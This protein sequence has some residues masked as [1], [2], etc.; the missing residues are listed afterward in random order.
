MG[1]CAWGD[2]TIKCLQGLAWWC[3]DRS[4]RGKSLDVVT[5]Y[6]HD[7]QLDAIE[8]SEL[9]YEELKKESNLDKP[10][11]FK[12]E[13]WTEWEESVYNYFA[14]HRNSK[15]VPYSYVIRKMPNPT[16][17]F[18][19]EREYE[20]IYFARH[21]GTAF[22]RDSKHVL[23]IL[24][25]LTNGTSAE[26]WMKG[27]TCGRLAFLALQ[28][29]YDGKAEG[30]RRKAVVRADLEKIF[31]RNEA[32]FPFETF[33]TK[34]Q[35]IFNVLEKYGM[36]E[37]EQNKVNYLLDK[38][39]CPDKRFQN[40]V[41]IA[42]ANYSQT[43]IQAATYLQTQ[44]SRIFPQAQP[45]SGRYKKRG[46]A[47]LSKEQGGRGHWRGGGRGRGRGG[48]GRG[49]GRG[50]GG[51][52]AKMENG[53]DISDPCRW[54]EPDEPSA[55]TDKTC[56]EILNNPQRQAAIDKRKRKR[57]SSAV[58]ASQNDNDRARERSEL[59][60]A[61]MNA[62]GQRNTSAVCSRTPVNGSRATSAANRGP[63]SQVSTGQS[64][65]ASIITYD[66]LG[67]IVE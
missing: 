17:P 5:F 7:A 20:I 31:Y 54:Y 43:F 64:D 39:N 61:L 48:R 38:I 10:E 65:S 13:K 52:G 11:K 44:V 15:G 1:G 63:P 34:L 42:R 56:R 45:T 35:H 14:S 23:Q 40:H 12:T 41:D 29:H 6:N 32:T 62:Q 50:G 51:R 25:E 28:D 37:Y 3:T 21:E 9:D 59:I 22:K 33:V 66:H 67:N 57:N 55:L 8:E 46:I 19:M 60:T 49:R 4:L 26:T 30:E 53:I 36:P 16:P 47:G 27:K 24:K 18:L 58:T 2:R